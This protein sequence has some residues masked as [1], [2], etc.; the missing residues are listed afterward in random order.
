MN[1]IFREANGKRAMWEKP[2]YNGS[3]NEL[4]YVG[5]KDLQLLLMPSCQSF[6]V[7]ITTVAPP[8]EIGFFFICQ[9]IKD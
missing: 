7:A 3:R 6:P 4:V 8:N 5:F 1:V 9:E 2:K